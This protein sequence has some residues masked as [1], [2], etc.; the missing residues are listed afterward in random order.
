GKNVSG[1]T[2]S[3]TA[4]GIAADVSSRRRSAVEVVGQSLDRIRSEDARI[5]AFLEISDE[6]AFA[7]ARQVD[8][9]IS[10][11]ET[12]PLAGV[13]LVVKDNMWVSG[14][15]VT[16]ASKILEGFRPPEDATAIERLR[17]AGAV[18]VG[19]TNLDEFAMGSSTE[20]SAYLTTR[21]PWDLARTPG[22]SSG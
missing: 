18:F 13:P 10:A 6:L 21:N 12:L 7:E 15:R 16:C 11:G 14:R 4:V 20:N 22:G 19:K 2:R 3:D 8:Q 9:R 5:G 17:R 1:A